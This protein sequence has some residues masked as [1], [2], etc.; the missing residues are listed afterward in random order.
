MPFGGD[1]TQSLTTDDQL[2]LGHVLEHLRLIPSGTLLLYSQTVDRCEIQNFQIEMLKV[3]L[4]VRK[5]RSRIMF[6]NIRNPNLDI[7]HLKFQLSLS[8]QD[9]RT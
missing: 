9:T 5:G 4:P 1:Y 6:I 3:N 8:I 2:N 7:H